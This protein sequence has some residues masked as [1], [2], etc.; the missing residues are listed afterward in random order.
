MIKLSKKLKVCEACGVSSDEV[1]IINYERTGRFLCQR[2]YLQMRSH[3]EILER[4]T[5]ERNK[6]IIHTKENYAEIELY[7]ID[8]NIT[9]YTKIDI[10]D[11]EKVKNY[12][13]Q[14]HKQRTY[15][16][17]MINGKGDRLHRFVLSVN[18]PKVIVD[19]ISGDMLDNRKFNLRIC[20]QSENGMN[21]R[22]QSNN[23][24]GI[25]GI[26]LRSD[27]GKWCAR[28]KINRKTINLGCFTDLE[29]AKK[30]RKEAEEKYFG[31]FSYDNSRKITEN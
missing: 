16:S 2:H 25:P 6:I 8:H 26:Y 15:V 5:K 12:K 14:K 1:R 28:I 19:H 11:V 4:T 29:E 10:E 17:A 23:T 9:G 7:D 18:N 3:G 27:T 13:W 30:V 22:I 21:K 20:T 31:E 24:S